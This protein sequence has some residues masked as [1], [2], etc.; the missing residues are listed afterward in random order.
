[1]LNKI[2]YL[3]PF[4]YS[5]RSPCS[6]FFFFFF[7]FLFAFLFDLLFSLSLTLIIDISYCPNYTLLLL[8]LI[9]SRRVSHLSLPSIT[10]NISTLIIGIH[11][12]L[13]CI[14]L[15]GH[16]IIKQAPPRLLLDQNEQACNQRFRNRHRQEEY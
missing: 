15:L 14:S 12:C 7:D 11:Y 10:F 9:T 13:N 4:R 2:I 8:H 16:L 1:M 3:S 5:F 6:I